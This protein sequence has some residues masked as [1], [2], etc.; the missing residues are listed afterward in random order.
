M[1][2][3]GRSVGSPILCAVR[4]YTARREGG[5]DKH[6]TEECDPL[7][8]RAVDS[9]AANSTS[10][11]RVV[12]V[13]VTRDRPAPLATTLRSLEEQGSPLERIVVVDSGSTT[14]H[15]DVGAVRNVP[16]DLV[17]A[18]D[19]VGYG[20]GLTMGMRAALSNSDPDYFWLLDDDSP[21]GEGSLQRAV[22]LLVANP[23]LDVLGNRG[24]YYRRGRV[25]H[26]S[27]EGLQPLP[28]D[29]CLV[30][31]ALVSRNAVERVGFPRT[32]FFMMFEDIEYTTR[33][34]AAGLRLAISSAV[35]SEPMH[36]GSSSAAHS[37]HWRKYYQ[38]RNHLR[39]V[40]DRRS[41]V[42]VFGWV[43]REMA[44]I[45]SAVRHRRD[46]AVQIR[47]IGLG[48]FDAV[49]GRM[50]RTIEPGETPASG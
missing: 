43:L 2:R 31:G 46:S 28:V 4:R 14:G 20:A 22:R 16:V 26:L 38:A 9:L 17:D 10:E 19:N 21:L 3:S 34:A 32:D 50:G 33:I 13:V 5:S 11:P 1:L 12:A 35:T 7:Y 36:L 39:M 44:M 27:R 30:D 15:P 48:A 24:G 18:Q 42:G 29:F 41:I 45:V 6:P 23:G 49:R 40:L 25:R 37:S 8:E 47:L